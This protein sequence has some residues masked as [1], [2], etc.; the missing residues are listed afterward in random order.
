MSDWA[1]E[2]AGDVW[3]AVRLEKYTPDDIDIIAAA[4]RQARLDAL[5][6][7]ASRLDDVDPICAEWVRQLKERQP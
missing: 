5:E 7:A 3:H 1:D 6:E 4:L 2:K